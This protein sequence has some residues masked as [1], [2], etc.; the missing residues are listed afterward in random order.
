MPACVF[1]LYGP[2]RAVVSMTFGFL[3]GSSLNVNSRASSPL[4]PPKVIL[5]PSKTILSASR[6][7]L[8]A[9]RPLTLNSSTV[10][11]PLICSRS[12]LASSARTAAAAIN[13]TRSTA[14]RGMR[15]MGETPVSEGPEYELSVLRERD[16]GVLEHLVEGRLHQLGHG[17]DRVGLLG[18]VH[19]DVNPGTLEADHQV[20]LHA[21]VDG[22]EAVA[23]DE[24]AGA[25]DLLG[26]PLRQRVC[27]RL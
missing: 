22:P 14:A 5:S 9:S 1:P 10:Q 19:V 8:G 4:P 20:H 15:R 13:P 21:L 26:Q 16:V 3:S 12:F 11:V 7:S 17:D 27:Q 2:V 23:G 6:T 18:L 24:A 25:I